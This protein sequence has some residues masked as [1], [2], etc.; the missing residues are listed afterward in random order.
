MIR[1]VLDT[2][3]TRSKAA[4]YNAEGIMTERAFFEQREDA[5]Q[6]LKSK[7]IQSLI[8]ASVAQAVN[9]PMEGVFTHSLTYKSKLPFTNQ[10]SSPQ[11]LGVDRIAALAQ[12]AIQFQGKAVLIFDIG[13][14]MTV[15]FLSPEGIYKGGNISPGVDMRLKAMHSMTGLLPLV[16]KNEAEEMMGHSTRTAIANGVMRGMKFEI[17]GYIDFFAKLYNDLTIVLCGGNVVDFDKT[18]KYEIFAAQNF[19]LD[20]LYQLLLLNEN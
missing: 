17:D 18:L 7:N 6:W 10:Y 1:G 8:Q 13:T 5:L 14:C 3:N 4:I 2:G 20:G 16:E 9:E 12:A 19:V 15:D 11:T